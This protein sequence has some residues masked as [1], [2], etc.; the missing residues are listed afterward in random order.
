[1]KKFLHLISSCLFLLISYPKTYAQ[2]PE[3]KPDNPNIIISFVPQYTLIGGIRL[4]LDKHIGNTNNYL[5]FS[6]QFYSNRNDLFWSF[7]YE[8][9]TGLG[10][11]VSHRYFIVNK[12]KPSG[13]YVQ[14]GMTYNFTQLVYKTIDWVNTDFGGAQAQTE[15][16]V[17]G[18]DK[19]HKIGGDL[20][21]G[22][23]ISSYENLLFDLY[24][25]AGYRESKYIGTRSDFDSEYIGI[26]NPAYTGILPL[27]GLRIGVFF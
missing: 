26:L 7:D 16:E 21:M 6:P 25:G 17:E 22:V 10:M 11:K 19:I 3:N 13:L 27:A 14:Y 9:L 18:K 20:I 15:E 4:D 23:Q 1:M 24:I 8:K 5:I 12:P 2:E